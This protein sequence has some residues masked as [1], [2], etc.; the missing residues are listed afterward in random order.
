MLCAYYDGEAKNKYKSQRR[1]LARY[2]DIQLLH[3][4]I[5]VHPHT[6]THTH[7]LWDNVTQINMQQSNN[8]FKHTK[9]LH[10]CTDY[11][12]YMYGEE[13]PQK[14]EELMLNTDCVVGLGRLNLVLHYTG[15]HCAQWLRL[16]PPYR[17]AHVSKNVVSK[18]R[19]LIICARSSMP[20]N[21]RWVGG[22][23]DFT[24]FLRN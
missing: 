12:V 14:S 3:L 8:M 20:Q 17:T 5:G 11:C 16:C 6:L 18:P 24:L 7:T 9:A 23:C 4:P 22:C 15:A 19:S 13:V 10:G 1:H 21:S 2:R